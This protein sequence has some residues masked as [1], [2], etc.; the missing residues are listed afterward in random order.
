MRALTT[1][2]SKVL[3]QKKADIK[4]D[5]IPVL[6]KHGIDAQVDEI[7]ERIFTKLD[8]RHA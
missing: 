5:I 2:A 4:K 7:L 8:N 3:E 1:Q 6:K